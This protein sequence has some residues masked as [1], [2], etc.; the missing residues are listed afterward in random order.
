MAD[1]KQI[2]EIND[3]SFGSKVNRRN[4]QKGTMSIAKFIFIFRC[5]CLL[6]DY[7]FNENSIYQALLYHY[8]CSV[9]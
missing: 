5:V 4:K 8:I 1:L 3:K 6:S 7:E 2:K 9:C